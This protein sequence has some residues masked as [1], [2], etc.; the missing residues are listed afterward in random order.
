[1][2]RQHERHDSDARMIGRR[3]VLLAGAAAGAPPPASAA[4]PVPPGDRIGFRLIRH[5]TEIGRHT[6]TFEQQGD[7]LTV[8]ISAEARVT[9][10]SIPIVHYTHRVIEVW[11][12]GALA[13]V[14]GET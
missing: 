9:L 10:L 14:T 5:G 3:A 2:W 4:L 12:D 8:R 6:L 7:T 11:Q 1:M 13:S